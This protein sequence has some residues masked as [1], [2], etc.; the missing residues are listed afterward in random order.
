M[1]QSNFG[2]YVPKEEFTP[3]G[4]RRMVYGTRIRLIRPGIFGAFDCPDGGRMA[5]KRS[6]STTPV[7]SLG[8]FNSR[9][10]NRQAGF[11]A[12][13][14]QQ[15]GGDLTTR[16]QAMVTWTLGRP[17]DDD[18]RKLLVGLAREF[19]IEQVGRVLLNSNEFVFLE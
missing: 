11:L 4:W 5:P 2:D 6:R 17:M 15:A 19:G 9:F 1:P 12:R 16:V 18:E 14:S 10:V 3:V 8:L 7:Q 13:R